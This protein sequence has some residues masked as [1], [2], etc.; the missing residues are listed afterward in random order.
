[1]TDMYYSQSTKGFYDK[2]VHKSIPSDAIQLTEESCRA[3]LDEQARGSVIQVVEGV[4]AA[5]KLPL[6]DKDTMLLYASG[7]QALLDDTAKAAGYDD[8]YT[9]VTYAEEPTVVKF[10]NDGRAFRKWRSLVWDYTYAQ[11][12]LVLNGQRT[13]PTVEEFLLELPA[14]ELVV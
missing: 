3:L 11:L 8:I 9:A 7:I 10:Q 4:I 14:L 13:K 12:E 6:S 2:R 5:Q 1:M